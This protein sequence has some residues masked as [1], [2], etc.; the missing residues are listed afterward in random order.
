MAK[1]DRLARLDEHRLEVEAEY[2]ILLIAALRRTAAGRPGLFGHDQHR[3]AVADAAPMILE[4]TELGEEIDGMRAQLSMEPFDLHRE[5]LA[6]RGPVKAHAV[7]E[8]K[9]AQAWLDR[10]ETT[11]S[12]I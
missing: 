11:G 3:R 5:F 6:S 12:D 7:G 8:P 9:Q 10:L 2:R 1:A 4:I